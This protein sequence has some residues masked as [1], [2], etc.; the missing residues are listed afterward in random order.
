MHYH[1]IFLIIKITKGYKIIELGGACSSYLCCLSKFES[2]A[3][4]AID[5]SEIGIKKTHELFKSNKVKV[6]GITSDLFSHNFN[7][8][9]YDMV[10]HFGLI[11]HF[12]DPTSI[13]TLSCNLL[14][15]HG[16]IFMTMPN[17]DAI[18]TYLWK[19][20]DKED[21]DCHIYHTD[22]YI[23]K[24]ASE[25]GFD[26]VSVNYWGAPLLFNTGFWIKEKSVLKDVIIILVRSFSILNKIIPFYHK[27][28]KYF[29]SYRG[30][31][32]RKKYH[33]E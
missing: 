15:E 12:N 26:T 2:I 13:F 3:A 20:Y 1:V 24:I 30:F 14:N 8:E 4:T 19:K 11:E 23:I 7:N 17:M 5:Y 28:N 10:V 32:F 21:L 6:V 29:S 33:G 9:K 31:V 16:S 27:G 22:D 18:G 25:A